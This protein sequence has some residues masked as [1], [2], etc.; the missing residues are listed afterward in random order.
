MY[1]FTQLL[2]FAHTGVIHE[3]PHGLSYSVMSSFWKTL[4]F[5]VQP[6]CFS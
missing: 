3:R 5:H 4:T 6:R 2:A 1:K